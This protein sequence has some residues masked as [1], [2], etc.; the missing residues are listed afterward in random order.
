MKPSIVPPF[1][2]NSVWNQPSLIAVA[3]EVAAQSRIAAGSAK[4]GT[5]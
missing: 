2:G 4:D 1:S 5:N 3:V